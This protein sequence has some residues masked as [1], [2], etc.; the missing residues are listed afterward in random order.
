MSLMNDEKSSPYSDRDAPSH[1]CSIRDEIQHPALRGERAAVREELQQL[2]ALAL[3]GKTKIDAV[4]ADVDVVSTPS[5]LRN[6]RAVD[7]GTDDKT[8]ST[9]SAGQYVRNPHSINSTYPHD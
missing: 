7:E 3:Q 8:P 1:R 5:G 6:L 4:L 9:G 2:G